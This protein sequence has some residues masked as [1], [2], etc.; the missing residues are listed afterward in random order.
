MRFQI[1]S[2]FDHNGNNLTADFQGKT[3]L[4]FFWMSKGHK[5]MK[6]NERTP[7]IYT[8]SATLLIQGS[9]SKGDR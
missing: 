1:P 5:L 3:Y 8:A 7:L 2:T 9:Q 4:F 6:K